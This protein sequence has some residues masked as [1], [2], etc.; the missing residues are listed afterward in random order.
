MADDIR[1]FDFESGKVEKI[2]DTRAQEIFPMWIG[3]E[4]FFLSDRDRIMN[5][6]VY[7]T[8][9]GKTEKVTNFDT[10]DIKFPSAGKDQIVFE[11]GGYIYRMDAKS[12]KPEKVTIY[13]AD[14]FEA[15]M[16]V[17]KDA[18]ERITAISAS[19]DG[20][21]VV[22]SA[23]GDIFNVPA[24]EGVTR[25]ITATS[26][27]HERNARWSPD[28]KNI[29]WVSDKSGEF[30]IWMQKA[31][32]SQPA[33]MV[34]K[35]QNTYLF[36]INWSPDSKKILY[37]A[38]K[39]DLRYVD[40]AS[41]KITI[42]DK[43]PKSPD[44]D[45]NWSPDSKWIAFVRQEIGFPIIRI[46]NLETKKSTPVTNNWYFSA[47]PVFS[48]DG[49]YLF[50]TSERDFNPVYSE[51]EWNHAYVDMSRI[52]SCSSFKRYSFTACSI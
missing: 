23:R 12:R 21:R 6:F 14:D 51:T 27:V 13:L 31:D 45:A 29:A 44:Y 50:F 4:I 30:E 48:E 41:G 39:N 47:D 40:V 8:L 11:N 35:D 18:S 19:P 43:S 17:L 20:E 34:T 3:D 2:T 49:K 25:N 37:T 38:K 42:V 5:M 36:G 15:G 22:F 32:R 9:T 10:Y 33:D 28:G 16:K 52:L 46:Y 7:N 26:G 1:I 24:K